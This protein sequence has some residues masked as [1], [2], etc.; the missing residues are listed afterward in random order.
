MTR[1]N[2]TFLKYVMCK[3]SF[4]DSW[5]SMIMRCISSVSYSVV[6]NGRVGER[7]KPNRG[8]RQRNPPSPLFLICKEGLSSLIRLAIQDKKLKRVKA[9]KVSPQVSYPLFV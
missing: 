6:I 9:S 8:L 1:L 5:I 4:V 7:F 3:M 2:E